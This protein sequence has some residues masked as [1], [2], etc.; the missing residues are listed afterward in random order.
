VKDEEVHQ[1][2]SVGN[3][4][5]GMKVTITGA[6]V[7]LILTATSAQAAVS[8]DDFLIRTT[9]NLVNLCAADT[10][11]PLYAPAVNFCQA[12]GAGVFQ[13]QQL[14]QAASRGKPLFCTPTPPPT[15]N[16]AMNGFVTWAKATPAVT[17]IVPAAGI[18][19]Y[20]LQTY[21]CPT[22]NH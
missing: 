18:M 20:L 1:E 2:T 22:R 21:P 9:G 6:A 5:G 3:R 10:K 14:Y 16:E 15:R 7:V 4:G 13:A 8:Q 11:D 19:Q 12:F 17:D